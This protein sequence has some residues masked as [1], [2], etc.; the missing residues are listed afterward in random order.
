[1]TIVIVD[2][3]V[4][5]PLEISSTADRM[6]NVEREIRCLRYDVMQKDALEISLKQEIE[7]LREELDKTVL[8]KN[9]AE[10]M[11][12]HTK[13][14]QANLESEKEILRS[15]LLSKTEDMD[16]LQGELNSSKAEGEKLASQVK[17]YEEI[18]TNLASEIEEK[19]KKINVLRTKI[20][21]LERRNVETVLKFRRSTSIELRAEI[22]KKDVELHLKESEATAAKAETRAVK[23]EAR[24]MENQVKDELSK[25]SKERNCF[26]IL[27]YV[28]VAVLVVVVA[29]AVYYMYVHYHR[30]G[31]CCSST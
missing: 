3:S 27:F 9:K 31:D 21:Q 28:V 19:N 30:D 20:H 15:E 2:S 12:R 16:G 7:S 22:Q 4:R 1:M 14:K 8:E 24:V 10:E 13:E 6:K 23:A 26:C 5:K 18:I 25:K 17:K 11:V 29:V